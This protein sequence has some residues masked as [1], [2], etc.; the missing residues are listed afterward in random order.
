MADAGRQPPGRRTSFS[1]ICPWLWSLAAATAVTRVRPCLH[2]VHDDR[3]A[4]CAGPRRQSLTPEPGLYERL[5]VRLPDAWLEDPGLAPA[6]RDVLRPHQD[7]ITWDLP[8]CTPQGIEQLPIPPRA[9]NIKPARHGTLR[10]LFD[11]YDYCANHAISVYG[12]GMA[13]IGSGCAGASPC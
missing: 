4:A 9:I 13:E 8:V 5:A 11:V 2:P 3:A 7:R 12:G 10:R 1:P 6:T